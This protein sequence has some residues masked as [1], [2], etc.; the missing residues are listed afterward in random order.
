MICGCLTPRR[1][2]STLTFSLTLC[3][4]VRASCAGNRMTV[5]RM[6]VPHLS[7]DY[8]GNG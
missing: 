3:R 1:A 4:I 6:T 8:N 2:M 7:G 5:M